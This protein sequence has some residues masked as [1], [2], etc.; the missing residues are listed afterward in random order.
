[1]VARGGREEPP[2]DELRRDRAVPAVLLEPERDVVAPAPEGVEAASLAEGDRT[3]GVDPLAAD[4]EAEM[5][6]FAHGR[7]R[8]QAAARGEQ[9]HRGVPEAERREPRQL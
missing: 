8:R 1:V 4:P 5:L 6:P 3:A 9:G 2:D 7:E